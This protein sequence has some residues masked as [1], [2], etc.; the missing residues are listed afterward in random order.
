MPKK[1]VCANDVFQIK[2]Q[3]QQQQQQ[4][5]EQQPEGLSYKSDGDYWSEVLKKNILKLYA[6][7]RG[8]DVDSFIDERYVALADQ[9]LRPTFHFFKLFPVYLRLI[10]TNEVSKADTT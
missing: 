5:N 7:L 3:Q 6:T 8:I 9:E 2:Q 10:N 1:I 4:T